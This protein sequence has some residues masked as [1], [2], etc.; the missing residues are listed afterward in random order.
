MKKFL[1]SII[2]LTIMICVSATITKAQSDYVLFLS[3]YLDPAPG[4][5]V[6][7]VEGL[8][9]HNQKF[10]AEGDDKAYFWSILT[11]PRSGQFVWAQGPIKYSKLDV[12]L[13]AEHTADWEKNVAAN[14]VKVS[15]YQFS[16][17]NEELTYNPENETVGENILARIFYGISDQTALLE[18]IG[19][20]KAVCEAKKY[21]M[22]RRVYTS[23]F[24][25]D[26]GEDVFLI[27]PFS[28]WTEFESRRGLPANFSEDFDSVHGE[29]SWA[30]T[31]EILS[32]SAEG[33]YDEVRVMVK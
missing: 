13:T 28:S 10:H 7:L 20:I 32:A 23:E 22:A 33:W 5:G 14:C 24:R 31:T 3:I 30:K 18:G 12:A 6:E 19:K 25:S 8:K 27:Y 11:G 15:N 17:R 26:K 4:K 21:D 2:R 29:G 1:T 16:K 9:A